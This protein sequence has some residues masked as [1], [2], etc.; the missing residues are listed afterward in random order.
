[1]S[2][3]IEKPKSIFGKIVENVI[4]IIGMFALCYFGYIYYQSRDKVEPKPVLHTMEIADYK[5][6]Y[7]TLQK[8]IAIHDSILLNLISENKQLRTRYDSVVSVKQKSPNK[9]PIFK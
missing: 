1:M 5:Y 6:Q 8:H 9:L 2:E 4:A 3:E 7:E